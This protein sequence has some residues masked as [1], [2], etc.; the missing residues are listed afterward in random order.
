MGANR[1][2]EGT[3]LGLAITKKLVEMMGVG[4]AVE[5]E[6]GKTSVFAVEI[7][8][9]LADAAPIGKETAGRLRDFSYTPVPQVE[10][11]TFPDAA[12]NTAH[13]GKALAVDD[14]PAN[15]LAIKGLL[16]PYG[17]EADTA[18]SGREALEKLR[19][20]AYYDLIFMDHMMPETDGKGRFS[21]STNP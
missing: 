11:I 6:H 15:L 19:N 9:G 8:Q 10:D 4:I 16:T 18:A 7:V 3:G 20:G 5:S 2:I 17:I 14:K 12:V 21:P 13:Y 1:K